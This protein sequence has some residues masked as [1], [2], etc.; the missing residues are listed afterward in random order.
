M[1]FNSIDT[2]LVTNGFQTVVVNSTVQTLAPPINAVSAQIQVLK[3]SGAFT[4]VQRV[5]RFTQADTD[6]S[7]TTG[8]V[9]GDREFIKLENKA[10]MEAFKFISAE[11][12]ISGQLSIQYFQD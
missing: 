4:D 5:I 10:Q 1:S 7:T 9:L 2:P 8:Q 12:A 3:G 6:P 11:T